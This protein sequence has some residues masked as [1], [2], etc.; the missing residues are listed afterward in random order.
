MHNARKPCMALT[1]APKDLNG[2]TSFL[3]QQ[4][5]RDKSN[6]PSS[7]CAQVQVDGQSGLQCLP[8]VK[9]VEMALS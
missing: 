7:I 8:A 3:L 6:I 9:H 5:A 2:Q 1:S 4:S